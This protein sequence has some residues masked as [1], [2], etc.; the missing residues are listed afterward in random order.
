MRLD[1][2]PESE[3]IEDRRGDGGFGGGGMGGMPIG[4]GGLGIGGM[5]VLGLIG[6][7]LGIDPRLLI[8]GAEILTGGGSSQM[9][10]MP[11]QQQ[12]RAGTPSA[13]PSRCDNSDVDTLSLSAIGKVSPASAGTPRPSFAARYLGGSDSLGSRPPPSVTATSPARSAIA[14][15]PPPR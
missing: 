10:P 13:L 8:G 7:A 12:G 11:P 9:Q 3:N 6:Y 5:I 15:G 1:D 14:A 4:T 2:L